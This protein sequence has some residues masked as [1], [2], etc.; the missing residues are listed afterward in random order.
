MDTLENRIKLLEEN[1]KRMEQD[2]LAYLK[3]VTEKFESQKLELKDIN[4]K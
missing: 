1:V 3:N 2:K 4:E